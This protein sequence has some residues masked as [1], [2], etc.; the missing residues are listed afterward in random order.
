MRSKLN[1]R[2]VSGIRGNGRV[3]IGALFCA[4][5]AAALGARSLSQQDQT[6]P[7]QTQENQAKSSN[8]PAPNTPPAAS[9]SPNDAQH[10]ASLAR[11]KQIADE[12]AQLLRLAT[13][14]KAEV[15]K[16]TKD[17]LSVAV[18]RKADAVERAAHGVKEKIRVDAASN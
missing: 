8:P 1:S 11:Q 12:S 14:L 5:L 13:D 6:Q 3:L 17:T 18:I 10:S 16:S 2:S 7:N 4:L 9:A 15:D